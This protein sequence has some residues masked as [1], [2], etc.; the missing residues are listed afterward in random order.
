MLFHR[1]HLDWSA[2]IIVRTTESPRALPA[3][4]GVAQRLLALG[5]HA[6]LRRR[7]A[8]TSAA[9]QLGPSRPWTSARPWAVPLCAR[10]PP[11]RAWVR[12]QAA[13][14]PRRGERTCSSRRMG[15]DSG[16]RQAAGGPGWTRTARAMKTACSTLTSAADREQK[17]TRAEDDASRRRGRVGDGECAAVC[18]GLRRAGY[19]YAAHATERGQYEK[20]PEAV[21]RRHSAIRVRRDAFVVRPLGRREAVQPCADRWRQ[22]SVLHRG[23]T[24]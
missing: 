7:L 24:S 6:G 13:A 16:R 22:H 23:Q 9:A 19:A 17:M 5:G 2:P 3:A 21:G 15:Q 1:M 20:R 10:P 18:S 11:V 12:A 8:F 14:Q 4:R